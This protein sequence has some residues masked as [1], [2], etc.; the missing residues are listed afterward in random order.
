MQVFSLWPQPQTKEFLF[1]DYENQISLYEP[2]YVIS[3]LCVTLCKE[4]HV[5]ED[6]HCIGCG[7]SPL[8]LSLCF[9]DHCMQCEEAAWFLHFRP[10][11]GGHGIWRGKGGEC[12]W[13]SY[14]LH[15]PSHQC[16]LTLGKLPWWVAYQ[17]GRPLNHA[18]DLSPEEWED[19]GLSDPTL[20]WNKAYP[21]SVCSLERCQGIFYYYHLGGRDNANFRD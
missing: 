10:M 8:W 18:C 20:E 2:Y 1:V 17:Q 3:A 15:W 4:N 9:S 13:W 21:D 12:L 16:S 11:G 14:G 19:C 5:R 6:V 7:Y